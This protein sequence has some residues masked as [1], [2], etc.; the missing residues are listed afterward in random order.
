M[1]T[2][3]DFLRAVL[4]DQGTYCVTGIKNGVAKNIFVNDIDSIHEEAKKLVENKVNAFYAMAT[5]REDESGELRRK[6]SQ[7]QWLKSFWIDVDCGEGKPYAN[8]T[9]GLIALRNFQEETELPTPFV[10]NSGNGLH[11]YWLIKDYVDNARWT[12]VAR[13]LK[14]ACRKFGFDVDLS[15]MSDSARVLRIPDTCNFKD[16]EN[17]KAVTVDQRGTMTTIEEFEAILD[18]LGLPKQRTPAKRVDMKDMSETAKALMGNKVSKFSTIVRK[19]LKGE[20][21]NAIKEI[22][23]N[24]EGIDEPLWRAG[25]A[26]AWACEDGEKAIHI[27]SK[28]HPDYDADETIEK[29]SLTL[30]PYTCD[31]IRE[32][33]PELCEG[34]TQ[35]CTSP[36][37]IGTEIKRATGDL[38]DA[39]DEK[40][41]GDGSLSTQSVQKALYKPP[42]PYFRGANGGIYV[43]ER[44]A[45]G[46][47]VEKLIY[48][49]DL[50]PVKRIK[51]PND[52]ESIVMRLHL[53]QDGMTEFILPAKKLMAGDSFRDILGGQGVVAGAK[54]MKD[55]MEYTIRFTKELQRKQKAEM[56]RL[57]YGWADSKDTW[58]VGPTAYSKKGVQHNPASSTTSGM[59]DD[60]TP[61]GNLDLWKESF[62]MFTLRPNMEAQQLVA[63]AGFGAPLMPFTGLVGGATINLVSNGSG[64]GK[65]SAGLAALSVFGNPQGTLMTKGDTYLARLHRLGVHNNLVAVSDEMTGMDASTLSNLLYSISQG[66]SRHR[67]EKDANRERHNSSTWKTI[68]CTNSNSS[69]MSVLSKAK[70]RPD[71]EMM[72][73]M[74][75]NSPQVFVPEGEKLMAQLDENYGVA[76]Q[77]YAPWLVHH[78]E[79]LPALV[80]AQKERIRSEIGHQMAERFWVG[81]FACILGGGRASQGLGLHEFALRDLEDWAINQILIMR[82]EVKDEVVDADSLV[83]DFLMDHSNAILALG[84]KIN[85]RTGDN[86]WMHS[87]SAK[88]M[89]RFELEDN[90]MYIAKK[91]FREYCVN[92]QFTETEAL[93]ECSNENSNYRYVKTIK[94]RMMAGTNITA[95]AVACHVFKCS[96]EESAEIFSA[97]EKAS[98]KEDA[99]EMEP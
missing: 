74:E 55:I 90:T 88:L 2:D 44:D 20:G 26:I 78:M 86:I 43:E 32:I 81:T 54:Q 8:Q 53:P 61:K 28:K 42:F 49:Y 47:K 46:D 21:C 98:A 18:D 80:D 64:T 93:K 23:S 45:D 56:A 37:Q 82:G 79:K 52:G 41:V 34:C 11:V 69:M 27:M 95:P 10:I 71:G 19:S 36:I 14:A 96:E 30:G 35:K 31:T 77:V 68:F 83:G 29:A 89:A 40:P 13:K 94:K 25:L 15:V 1:T 91:A 22:V 7:T 16:P 17:P 38:F 99:G 9:D 75:I 3:T 5:Y 85:P 33:N 4:P 66:R 24:Q 87:R 97:L 70:A 6:Q 73:L 67:M 76:G 65:S 39:P 62:N 59:H 57:Q 84:T 72:R 60:F 58:V 12:P 63:L 51:D 92:R 50:Y 48:D